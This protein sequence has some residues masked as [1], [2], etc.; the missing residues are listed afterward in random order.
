MQRKVPWLLPIALR[1]MPTIDLLS[2]K[3]PLLCDFGPTT[4]VLFF[5]F[6]TDFG[7]HDCVPILPTLCSQ[8]KTDFSNMGLSRILLSVLSRQTN[9]C[10]HILQYRN[11]ILQ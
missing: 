2:K 8:I 7:F 6:P 5:D 1:L 3:F 10:L 9:D 11:K 4:G